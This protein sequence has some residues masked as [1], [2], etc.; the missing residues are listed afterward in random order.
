MNKLEMNLLDLERAFYEDISRYI[1]ANESCNYKK[2]LPCNCLTG[3]GL[4]FWGYVL[5]NCYELDLSSSIEIKQ[6]LIFFRS[7]G[8]DTETGQHKLLA[9]VY[10]GE[11]GDYLLLNIICDESNQATSDSKLNKAFLRR[12]HPGDTDLNDLNCLVE[13]SGMQ[14]KSRIPEANEL[15]SFFKQAI[16]GMRTRSM[17]KECQALFSFAMFFF[18]NRTGNLV[19]N[20]LQTESGNTVENKKVIQDYLEKYDKFLNQLNPIVKDDFTSYGVLAKSSC[21]FEELTGIWIGEWLQEYR[22]NLSCEEIIASALTRN[23]QERDESN[24]NESIWKMKNV[25][26]ES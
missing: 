4:N 6:G 5:E 8:I 13:K 14:R 1:G 26:S 3:L 17:E 10:A 9:P 20:Y 22:D 16:I 23:C 2:G 15:A 12:R 7:K 21:A 25:C 11:R 24:H 19:Y 18:P